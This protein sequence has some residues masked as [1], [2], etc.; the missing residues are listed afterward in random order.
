MPVMQASSVVIAVSPQFPPSLDPAF[1]ASPL[2]F[3]CSVAL[4]PQCPAVQSSNDAFILAP[5]RPTEHIPE[6]L[7]TTNA[8]LRWLHSTPIVSDEPV[9]QL[10]GTRGACQRHRLPRASNFYV[11]DADVRSLEL[12][13]VSHSKPVHSRAIWLVN[14]PT[15]YPRSIAIRLTMPVGLAVV[16][17][18]HKSH[19]CLYRHNSRPNRLVLGRTEDMLRGPSFVFPG[20]RRSCPRL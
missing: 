20:H 6:R 17:P 13:E 12:S 19:K 8:V 16:L 7:L 4:L 3:K 15:S 10:F 2:V 14:R 9:S 11:Q 5:N 1:S 18:S